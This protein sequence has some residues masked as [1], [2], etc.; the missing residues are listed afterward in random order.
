VLGPSQIDVEAYARRAGQS[1]NMIASH[2]AAAPE[3]NIR[4]AGSRST[5][6]SA[7]V[8]IVDDESSSRKVLAIMLEQEG[9]FCKAGAGAAEALEILDREPFDAVI[10]DLQMPG[11]SGLQLLAEVR[12]RF[13]EMAFLM[14]TGVDDV[15]VGV[16]AMREGA[17]DYLVKPFQCDV[18]LA[19]L[20]RAFRK[21]RLE[22]EVENYRHHLEKMVADQTHQLRTAF[23]QIESSYSNT[24]AALGAAIDLRDSPTAGHSHRVFRYST[25]IARALNLTEH[26]L[27]IIGFGALLHDIGKLAIPDS[28]LLKPGPLTAEEHAV[29]QKHARLGYE[30]VK[31]IEF[32]AEPAEII[33]TH[34]ERC[35]G[36]GYPGGLRAED[37]RIGAKIFA[38]ADTVDAMTSDRPYRAALSFQ[39]AQEQ[40]RS[41]LGKLYDPRVAEVF[42]H[43]SNEIWETIRA[44][45]KTTLIGPVLASP[46]ES[47]KT[48]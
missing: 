48:G 44:E 36:S 27:T 25:E 22:R 47:A 23:R 40:I 18:V 34:H 26:Q 16:Q 11:I 10:A 1:L 20:D 2:S 15:Q 32:L 30:M 8:L 42:L 43:I 41:G 31:G 38:V 24:L 33:L 28:I 21:K 6:S 7:R 14:G 37:I 46:L 29:M 13:P 5:P 3:T 4:N 39:A 12:R 19:C 17:D 9:L 45:T 35:D